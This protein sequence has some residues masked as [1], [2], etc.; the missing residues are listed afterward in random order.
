MDAIEILKDLARRPLEAAEGLRESL[1]PEL[2]NAHPEHDN[3]IA[4]LLWHTAREIDEQVAALSG[5]EPV[6]TARGFDARFGLDLEPHELGYGQSGRRARSIVV[7]DVGLLYEH[8]DAVVE[9]QV[10]YLGSLEP[11]DLDD[12][13][14]ENWDPPVTRAARLVSVSED[15]LQHVGQAAYVA[16]MGAAAFEG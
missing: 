9:A 11:A 3:S 14:D 7:D 2:L 5:R 16:G 8:L 13:V 10:E 1:T 6:W 4:W 12:V 15:A